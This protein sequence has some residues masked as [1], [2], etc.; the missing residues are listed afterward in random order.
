LAQTVPMGMNYQGVA[1]D[2]DGKPM[3]NQAIS[4]K[5]S[6]GSNE[7]GIDQSYYQEVHKIF[8]D[9]MGLFQLIIGKGKALDGDFARIPWAKEE[10]WLEIG[11]EEQGAF[12]TINNTALLSVPY[13]LHAETA[14]KLVP[15]DTVDLRNQSIYWTTSGNTK[16]KPPIHFLGTRDEEDLIVKTNN[17]TRV[18]YTKEGQVQVYSGVTGGDGDKASYPLTIEGSEQGIFIQVTA[19]RPNNDNNFV[20]F[21][22]ENGETVG[23]IEGQTIEELLESEE[24]R[25]EIYQFALTTTALATDLIGLGIEIGGLFASGFGAGAGAGATA[26]G[27]AI[28]TQVAALADAW[29]EF[30]RLAIDN[31][32]VTYVSGSGDYAESLPRGEGVRDLNFGEVVGVKGGKVY[33]N[34]ADADHFMVVSMAPIVLGNVPTKEDPNYE[35][36][37]FMGQVPVKVIG[38]VEV[39]DYILPSGNNDGF[40][41]AVNPNKMLPGDYRRVVGVAWQSGD[42]PLNMTNVAVGINSNDLAG[43]VD[44]LSR[45]VDLITAYLDGKLDAK[46]NVLDPEGLKQMLSTQDRVTTQEKLISDEDFDTYLDENAG[47]FSYIFEQAKLELDASGYQ[48]KNP[49]LLA[50]IF[51]DPVNHLKEIRRNPGYLSMWSEIDQRILDY[52]KKND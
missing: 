4:L 46:G 34:T 2:A 44:E 43:K 37:A 52:Q 13:A 32:G 45:K 10:I 11:L 29:A 49:E 22:N 7:T 21:A 15:K 33:L 39:G 48:P 3:A 30:E 38:K 47:T 41:I 36:I 50:Q 42:L 8:T 16:T 14:A 51:A 20:T 1:R 17:T 25:N 35:K 26:S 9:E 23:R 12:K 31:I 19:G 18:I 5:I 28:A 24:Y 27:V 6:L 40:A